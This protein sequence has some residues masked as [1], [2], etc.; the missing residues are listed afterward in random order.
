MYKIGEFS[1]MTGLSIKTLRYYDKEGILKPAGREE[2]AYRMYDQNNY[3]RA[4]LLK[5][6]RGL[7]FSIS[8]IKDTL[9]LCQSE[10]DISFVLSEKAKNVEAE[11]QRQQ[12][13]LER[14]SSSIIQESEGYEMTNYDVQIISIPDILVAS[15][16]Y[17]GKYDQCGEYF[18]KLAKV[19]KNKS[20]G[21]FMNL[22]NDMAYNEITEIQVCLPIKTGTETSKFDRSVIE[23]T[24][25]IVTTHKGPYD[26]SNDAYKALFDYANEHN[27][28]LTLPIREIYIKGPG[29][30]F[31][32]NP[33]NYVTQIV[34]PLDDSEVS[35]ENDH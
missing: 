17:T 5:R 6:L 10:E 19:V 24:R 11:I 21:P 26:K 35:N 31:K 25:A 3:S 28:K 2:N 14:L 32:G 7:D 23:K 34:I 9:A 20:N 30:I 8:E 18:G 29:M 27:L 15:T 12:N 16:K 22:Y 1:I 13:L 4:K 33:N